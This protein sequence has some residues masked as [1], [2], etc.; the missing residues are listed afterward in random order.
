LKKEEIEQQIADILMS[1]DLT[2]NEIFEVLSKVQHN[3]FIIQVKDAVIKEL[4]K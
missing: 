3:I 4:N 1:N 2:Y